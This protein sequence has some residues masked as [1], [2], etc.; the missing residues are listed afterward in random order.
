M[1]KYELGSLNLP[2]M[3]GISLKLFTSV[4]ENPLGKILLIRSLLENG[5]I[6]KLRSINLAEV[7][8]NFPVVPIEDNIGDAV[9][10]FSLLKDELPPN[11]FSARW[12]T[13]RY[14]SDDQT[15]IQVAEKTISNIQASENLSKPLHAFI[16]F[17][18]EDILRQA[19]ASQRR[20]EQGN[21]L[22]L[23]DGVP[24]AIKDE[25]DQL[26]YP[27]TVGTAFLGK[28]ACHQD[29]TVVKRLRAAGALLIGKTNMHEIGINPNGANVTFGA[30][31][32]PHDLDRD[33][34][35]SS[36]GSAAAVAAG[37]VPVAIGADGGGSI[38][39][40]AAL[41]G[42]VGL[43]ATYGRISEY[44][45]FPLCWS[46]AHLGPIAATVEDAALTYSIIAGRDPL[47]VNTLHQPPVTV[48]DWNKEDLSA[49]KIG[50]YRQWFENA[51][52]EIVESNL[53]MVDRMQ[54]M[55]ARV[56][57]IEV[58]E[59]DE[60]RIAHVISI[61]SEMALCM[62]PFKRYRKMQGH[63][64]RLSLI[65][66]EELSA[67]DYIQAQRMRTRALTIFDEVFRKVDVIL[68]PS[69]A[70]TAPL[71]PENGNKTGW[72]DL[73][74]DTEMMR[75]IFPANLT[76]IPAISFPT[77]YDSNGLPIGMQAMSRHWRE[78]L[79]LRVAYNAERVVKSHHP[80]AFFLQGV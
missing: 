50:I 27:T 16:A 59:L 20:Y 65:L 11:P 55:G 38:R 32:N 28:E 13:K 79:L 23:L 62:K 22:S 15:V 78:N 80:D 51:T 29:S 61:L 1:A 43:K 33:A 12:F 56:Q 49:I 52:A 54:Q 6:P 30:V 77:G 2:K 74:T 42:V 8:T 63:S 76:G 67:M 36:S 21:P 37:L 48:K 60:M 45:A 35:G 14:R 64:V 53:Q 39:I 73:A 10:G 25:I 72:S 46:V 47:D 66:G 68:T 19:H 4:A 17:D 70:M 18:Q 75:Y 31:R 7:P 58:P 71:I 9:E 41:C 5:G 57:E 34:G 26:P 44:G 40:P 3:S 24:V 69:T